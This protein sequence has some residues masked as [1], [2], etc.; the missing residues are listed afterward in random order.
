[1][2]DWTQYQFVLCVEGEN[3]IESVKEEDWQEERPLTFKTLKR[4][5]FGR[6]PVQ[7]IWMRSRKVSDWSDS[8][9]VTSTGGDY[10][11]EKMEE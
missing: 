5:K 7:A 4:D 10:L 6:M 9:P 3:D 1:M 8:R 11:D 2:A